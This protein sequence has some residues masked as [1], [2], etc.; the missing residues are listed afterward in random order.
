MLEEQSHEDYLIKWAAASIEVAGSDTVNKTTVLWVPTHS[1][2]QTG[3]QLEAF[4]LAMSLYPDVQMK[5]QEELD[6]VVGRDRL[7]ELSDRAELPYLN[8]LC[9]EVFRWHVASPV[10][11]YSSVCSSRPESHKRQAYR[12]APARII[13]TCI[14]EPGA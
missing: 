3:A 4:F 1:A 2:L 6:K 14:A 9:K 8:A 13:F 11:N 12:I 5:A 10:G 7:P